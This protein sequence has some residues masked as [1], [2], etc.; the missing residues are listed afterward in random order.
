MQVHDE[1]DV[2]ILEK[3]EKH[4]KVIH[5]SINNKSLH[6]DFCQIRNKA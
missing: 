2:P 6:R 3:K 5:E 1:F 4:G